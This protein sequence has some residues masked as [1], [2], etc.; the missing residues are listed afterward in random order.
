MQKHEFLFHHENGL[1][2]R[3]RSEATTNARRSEHFLFLVLALVLASTFS[4]ENRT[5]SWRPKNVPELVFLINQPKHSFWVHSWFYQDGRGWRKFEERVSETVCQF[6]VTVFI[7]LRY[8]ELVL[9]CF[10]AFLS[11]L[12]SSEYRCHIGLFFWCQLFSLFVASTSFS[13]C[14]LVIN[15][16]VQSGNPDRNWQRHDLAGSMFCHVFASKSWD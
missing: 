5:R 16:F 9:S 2:T 13:L 11:S 1:D 15:C 6:P 8:K 3:R 4:L 14:F 7:R 10:C 12:S